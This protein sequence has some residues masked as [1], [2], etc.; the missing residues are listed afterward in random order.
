MADDCL[1]LNKM[2]GLR[3]RPAKQARGNQSRR[4]TGVVLVVRKGCRQDPLFVKHPSVLEYDLHYQYDDRQQ[5]DDLE[6]NSDHGDFFTK[7]K[8]VSD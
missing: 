7:I 3:D 1:L 2:I 5:R 6:K 8:R 4:P